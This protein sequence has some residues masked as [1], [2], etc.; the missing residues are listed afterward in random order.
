LVPNILTTAQ[1]TDGL[2]KSGELLR[3]LRSMNN[4]RRHLIMTLD[5]CWFYLHE[6]HSVQW[7]PP[8][9]KPAVR[10]RIT[11]ETPKMMLTIVWNTKRFHVVE[12][13]PKGVKFNAGYFCNSILR[14]LVP[15]DGDV[16]RRKMVIHHDNARPHAAWRTR[17]FMDENSMKPAPHPPYSPD[18]APSDFSLFGYVKGRLTGQMFE[19][20]EDLFEAIIEILRSI[21]M[22][23][24]MSVFL[25]WERG[26]QRCIDINGEYVEYRFFLFQKFCDFDSPSRDAQT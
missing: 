11:V 3:L 5:E 24:L 25:K 19:S 23:K 21:P 8:G 2:G 14:A 9:E 12:I 7:L 18:L 16:G 10:E 1:K 15:D 17:A 20:R 4:G 26:L 22:E 6:D 13:L